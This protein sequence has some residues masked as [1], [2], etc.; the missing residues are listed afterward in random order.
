[1]SDIFLTFLSKDI[2][3]RKNTLF[4]Y[5]V[6]CTT[7]QLHNECVFVYANHFILKDMPQYCSIDVALSFLLSFYH[8][9]PSFAHSVLINPVFVRWADVENEILFLY[10]KFILR[11][12]FLRFVCACVRGFFFVLFSMS[13][14]LVFGYT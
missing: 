4:A 5:I 11:L 2:S 13:A 9:I 7:V 8:F 12:C 14:F 1:M 6:R 3:I 10:C